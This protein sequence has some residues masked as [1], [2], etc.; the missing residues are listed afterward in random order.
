[1]RIDPI[2]LD[3]DRIE[4]IPLDLDLVKEHCAVSGTRL[5]TTL[6]AYTKAAVIWAEGFMHR[7]IVSRPH[8]WVLRGFPACG[9]GEDS[10]IV[11]PR[12]KT[13]SVDGIEYSL[14]G[15]IVTLSGPSNSPAGEDYQ[16][17]LLGDDGGILMPN[18]GSGWP[19]ADWDVPAPVTI[20][21]IAGY[22]SDEIPEDIVH[23]VLFAIDD[24]LE[25][26]GAADIPVKLLQTSATLEIR[27]SLLSPYC[28]HRFYGN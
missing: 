11:L 24:C 19:V 17:S 12:G 18:R 7:S 26:K 16:E 9:I 10:Q 20:P 4:N 6:Q 27:Q 23:A 22:P 25:V 8:R 21:F 1:M 15:A 13:R 2:L 28:L 5:D 3:I 14:N